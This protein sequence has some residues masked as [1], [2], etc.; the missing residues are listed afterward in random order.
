MAWELDCELEYKPDSEQA[1][2]R[3]EAWWQGAILDRPTIQIGAPLAEPRLPVPEKQHATHRE[4]WLDLEHTVDVTLARVANTFFGGEIFPTFSPNL[5]PEILPAAFGCELEFT[6]NTSWA[7]PCLESWDDVPDLH[8]D[9]DNQYVKGIL[10]LTRLGVE[11]GKGKFITGLTDIHPGGDLAAALRDP[12]Q[13]ALDIGL[14]RER[15]ERLLRHLEPSFFVF[16][17]MGHQILRDA[18][19][20]LTTAWLSLVSK[21]R[22]YIPSNDFSCMVSPQDFDELFLPE[23]KLECDW[24][25]TSIYH[26][27]GPDAL[28]HLDSL[29][30]IDSLGGIQWVFGAGNGPAS[31]WMDV[32]Q[33]IQAAGKNMQICCG[34]DEIDVFMA[35]LNPEGVMITTGA[36]TQEAAEAAIEKVSKWTRK[37]G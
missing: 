1:L 20:T 26:L 22:Y 24:L 2:K 34:V 10:E 17:E 35:N 23:I 29:L 32:Y 14:E 3:M 16:Y 33:R 18:G 19:Q 7:V 36:R 13:L 15:V 9:T 30:S 8:L 37:T 11:R 4:R 28:R 5:G 6:E 27:D 25:D 12:Q 31:R 21:G